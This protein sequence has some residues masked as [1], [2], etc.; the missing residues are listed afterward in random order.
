MINDK[1]YFLDKEVDDKNKLIIYYK[2]ITDSTGKGKIKPK[3][4][5]LLAK[6]N[7]AYKLIIEHEYKSLN[8]IEITSE[9][10]KEVKIAVVKL[11]ISIINI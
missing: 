7:K 1:L 11:L 5:E 10:L 9:F 8:N 3:L 6:Y 2:K 4:E